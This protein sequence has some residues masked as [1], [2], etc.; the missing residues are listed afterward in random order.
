VQLVSNRHRRPDQTRQRLANEPSPRTGASGNAKRCSSGSMSARA[1][2]ALSSASISRR[3]ADDSRQGR[4]CRPAA[5]RRP[6][7]STSTRPSGR[8][9]ARSTTL[10]GYP[11]TRSIGPS[12]ASAGRTWRARTPWR[13]GRHRHQREVTREDI[14]RALEVARAVSI[15]SSRE[16]LHVLPRGFIVDG[17]EGVKDPLGMSASGSRSRRTSSRRLRPRF[18]TCQVRPARRREDRRAGGQFAGVRRSGPVG[19]GTRDR[20]GG[21]RHR[22]RH[23]R[24]GAFPR[25]LPVQDGVLPVGGNNVTNDVAIGLKTSLQV[26]EEA[27]DR[28]RQPAICRRSSATR[29]SACP[30]SA[31]LPAGPSA[32]STSAGSSSPACGRFSRCSRRDFGR[33]RRATA[34]GLVLTGG[35]AQLAG[36]AAL[37][38]E[39]LNMPVRV[40]GPTTWPV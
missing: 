13:R 33:R 39:I 32:A 38:R 4:W 30:C 11:G 21:R 17:Q 35:A 8:S 16:V 2:S 12:S 36:A 37:G 5:S 6:L 9:R 20:R 24:P 22:G 1:R 34:A 40:A 14:D 7:S 19:H 29:P 23:D 15:P 18:A 25:R 10:S 31:K 27:Q 28:A 3:D 26:A